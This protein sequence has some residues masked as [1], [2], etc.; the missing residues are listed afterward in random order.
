MLAKYLPR[1]TF[2][3]LAAAASLPGWA[4]GQTLS[5]DKLVVVVPFEAGSAPDTYARVIVEAMRPLLDQTIV[6]ENRPGVSGNIGMASV[7]RAPA[8]GTTIVVGTMALC[9]INP[10]VFSNLRWSM[11]EFAPIVKGVG[12]PLVLVT[13]PDVPAKTFDELIAWAKGKKGSL[14]YASYGAGTPS[15]FLGE[16]LN[17]S[18][19][20]DLAH[21][22]YRGSAS[23]ATAILAG[24]SP[25][26]FA[27]TQNTLPHIQSGG[28]RAIAVTSGERYRLLPDIPTF[29]QLGHPAFS[30]SVWFGLLMQAGAPKQ[31]IERI[32]AVALAAHKDPHV[33]EALGPQGYDMIGEA[34]PAF[35]A[36]MDA[37]SARWAAL[38]KATGFKA[39][40]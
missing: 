16:Q 28:L 34:G 14:A 36:S 38:V 21:V 25:F 32:A 30:T 18:F 31:A 20:L 22:A 12:A 23:Q 10:L 35:A 26:G 24:Q 29:Q 13:H 39:V 19:N 27:Q 7:A 9:E 2:L 6:V 4:R 5:S 17:Q 15:H 1:R 40:E 8:D 33:F 3:G 37:G 11:A